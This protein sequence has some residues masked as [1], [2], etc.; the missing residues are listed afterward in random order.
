MITALLVMA[1]LLGYSFW[2]LFKLDSEI[3]KFTSP[4]AKPVPVAKLDGAEAAL[5]DLK[6]RLEVFRAEI[7]ADPPRP[8]TLALSPADLNRSVAAFDEFRDLRGALHVAAIEDGRMEIDICFP[9]HG[10]PFTGESRFLNAT[11]IARPELHPGEVVLQ[12][13][14]LRVPGAEVP[15]EFLGHFSP[16]RVMERYGEHPLLGPAMKRLTGVEIED[17]ALV[18]RSIPGE[19]PPT[20]ITDEQVDRGSSRLLLAL[21]LVAAAFL[22]FGGGVVAFLVMRRRTRM[23]RID[24]EPRL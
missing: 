8:A 18:L 2:S 13:D 10:R 22:L 7:Q 17:G 19:S 9:M 20:L 1:F 21:G 11:M 12:V 3:A 24:D 4:A 16:Y 15:P 14:E 5:N 23:K 6:A